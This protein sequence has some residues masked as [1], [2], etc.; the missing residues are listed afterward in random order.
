MDTLHHVAFQVDDIDE[1]IAWYCAQFDV[2]PA[3]QDDTWALLEFANIRL[4]LVKPDQHP[5]HI[6]VAR[7]DAEAFGPLTVHRDGTAST[8]VRDPAG[9]IVEVLQACDGD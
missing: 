9:N 3:Y 5:P 6:A 4:A 1:A 7:G 2:V 8:Y